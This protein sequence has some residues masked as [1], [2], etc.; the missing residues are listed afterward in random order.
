MVASGIVD[1][2]RV[3][4]EETLRF[5]A[6]TAAQSDAGIVVDYIQVALSPQ[7]KFSI[8]T[9]ELEQRDWN[10]VIVSKVRVDGDAI[11]LEYQAAPIVSSPSTYKL[12][13][14]STVIQGTMAVALEGEGFHR[15]LAVQFAVA[16]SADC[17]VPEQALLVLPLSHAAYADLDELRVCNPGCTIRSTA[18]I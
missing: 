7:T 5:A 4:Q 17:Q 11:T 8:A 6:A 2:P 1:I 9:R 3:L 10:A 15:H 13:Q 12:N 18:S 14:P 16:D